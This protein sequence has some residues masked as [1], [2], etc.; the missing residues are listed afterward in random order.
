MTLDEKWHN[1]VDELLQAFIESES[2]VDEELLREAIHVLANALRAQDAIDP[3]LQHIYLTGI[4]LLN[5][6]S[7]KLQAQDHELDNLRQA[8]QAQTHLMERLM[9]ARSHLLTYSEYQSVQLT[10]ILRALFEIRDATSNEYLQVVMRPL[11]QY[12]DGVLSELRPLLEDRIVHIDV[13]LSPLKIYLTNLHPTGIHPATAIS[14]TEEMPLTNRETEVLQHLV[15]G[16]SAMEISEKLHVEPSTIRTYRHRI[17]QK[18]NINHLPGLV[19]YAL[20]HNL[21]TLH[22]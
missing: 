3:R 10:E 19:K 17:M 4:Q 6:T 8:A 15:S 20:R 7:E 1:D 21:T 18:L 12:I 5:R 2:L 22:E 14:D 9:E 13:A 16:L 11:L